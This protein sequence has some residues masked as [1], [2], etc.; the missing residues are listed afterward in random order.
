MKAHLIDT[1]QGHLSRSLT[2][3]STFQKGPFLEASVFLKRNLFLYDKE[4]DMDMFYF[5]RKS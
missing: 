2:E 1:H 3:N 4:L 5:V